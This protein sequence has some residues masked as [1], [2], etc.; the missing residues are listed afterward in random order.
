MGPRPTSG[1]R[2]NKLAQQE[3]RYGSIGLQVTLAWQEPEPGSAQ[4]QVL[5]SPCLLLSLP[6]KDFKRVQIIDQN[7]VVKLETE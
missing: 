3:P 2:L 5:T 4:A 7:G 6:K 1:Y